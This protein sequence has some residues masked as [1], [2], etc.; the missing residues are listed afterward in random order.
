MDIEH[1]DKVDAHKICH[2]LLEYGVMI[3]SNAHTI[4]IL[5]PLTLNKY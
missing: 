1:T 4:R 5:P 3:K 2:K